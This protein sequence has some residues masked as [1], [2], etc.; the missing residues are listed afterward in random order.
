MD[1][2]IFQFDSSKYNENEVVMLSRKAC[3]HLTNVDEE[4]VTKFDLECDTLESLLN[5]GLLDTTNGIFRA[6]I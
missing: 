2:A 6:F 1:R 3:E 4:N 5:E